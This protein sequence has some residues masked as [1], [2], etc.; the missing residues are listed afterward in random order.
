[1]IIDDDYYSCIV[2]L[3]K[4]TLESRDIVHSFFALG[5]DKKEVSIQMLVVEKSEFIR[6]LHGAIYIFAAIILQAKYFRVCIMSQICLT[7]STFDIYF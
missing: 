7:N 4:Q 5:N 3:K 2:Y 6:T 1:M